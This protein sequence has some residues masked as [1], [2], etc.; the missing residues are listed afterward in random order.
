MSNNTKTDT[1]LAKSVKEKINQG[2]GGESSDWIEGRKDKRSVR[3]DKSNVNVNGESKLDLSDN[4]AVL[5]AILKAVLSLLS[6]NDELAEQKKLVKDLEEKN[7]AQADLLD[8]IQQCSFKGGLIITSPE[9][10]NKVSGVKS[11]ED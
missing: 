2:L 1:E 9:G 11:Q 7:R 8:K 10:K 4:N 6:Q 3:G 5:N